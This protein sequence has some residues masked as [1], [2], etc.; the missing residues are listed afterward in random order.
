MRLILKPGGIIV[1]V[2]FFLVL[3]GIIT[4]SVSQSKEQAAVSAPPAAATPAAS[5]STIAAAPSATVAS[6]YA[7]TK[8]DPAEM[9]VVVEGKLINGTTRAD[10]KQGAQLT[11]SRAAQQY[12]Q[13]ADPLVDTTKSFSV[14]AWVK[15]VDTDGF[16]TFVS[17]DGSVISGFYFQKRNDSGQLSFSVNSDDSTSAANPGQTSLTGYRAQSGFRAE[18]G[19]W[20]H[21]VGCYDAKAQTTRLYVDGKLTETTQLPPS[22]HLWTAHG[23]TILGAALWDRNR[24]DYT[25]GIVENVKI[26]PRVVTQADVDRL[27]KEKP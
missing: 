14:S 20:Y 11:F 23:N 26:Y 27:Y 2:L 4:K 24:V 13:I 12:V 15:L 7:G 25:N 22:V 9:P 6:L 19:K 17:Q 16:Q 1:I 5:A 8:P 21:M 10:G 3:T 18:A